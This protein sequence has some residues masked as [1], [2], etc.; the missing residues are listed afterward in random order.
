MRQELERLRPDLD[1]FD[2]AIA[3][4]HVLVNG[5]PSTNPKT[6]VAAGTSI[7]VREPKVFRG[8]TK[9]RGALDAFDVEAR[10]RVALD[11]GASAGG[12]VQALL[13]AGA[14]KVYAVEVGYGQLLGSLRQDERVVNLERT[15]IGELDR[16]KVPDAIELISLDLGFLALATGVPQLGQLELAPG[17]DLLALVKPTAELGLPS[18]PEDEASIRGAVERASAAVA[19]AGWEVLGAVE[20]PI[21]GSRGAIE[22]FLH[23]RRS[24]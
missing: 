11:A 7:V 21:R 13:E 16:E 14:R 12:F 2:E 17:A 6:Q 10:G 15:N 23:G 18:P 24:A 20:S 22:W 4:G 19:G 1:D 9:L 5:V 8:L 3:G